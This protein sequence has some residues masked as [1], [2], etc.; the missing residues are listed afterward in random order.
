MSRS[1]RVASFLFLALSC[2]GDTTGPGSI[3][4]NYTLRTVNSRNLPAD[5]GDGIEMLSGTLAMREDGTCTLNLRFRFD[6]DEQD[7]YT[8]NGTYTLIGTQL[9]LDFDDLGKL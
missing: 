9:N 3:V 6:G 8:T 7:L 5:I 4:G 2:G 1:L